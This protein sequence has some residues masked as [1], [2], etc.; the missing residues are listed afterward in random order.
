LPPRNATANE[1]IAAAMKQIAQRDPELNGLRLFAFILVFGHH[2]G[3]TDAVPLTRFLEA[4]GWVG[5][6]LFFALSAFLLFKTLERDQVQNGGAISLWDYMV[7]R[8]ARIY[9]LMLGYALI[10]IA[11]GAIMDRT[12]PGSN[13][14]AS[15]FSLSLALNN[16]VPLFGLPLSLPHAGHLWT[17]SFE[18]QVYAAVPALF[19]LY[20][21]TGRRKFI[22]ILG[23]V[24]LYA[25]LA[26]AALFALGAQHPT[27]YFLPFARPESYLIGM[28][29]WAAQPKWHWGYSGA[30]AC[31]AIILVAILPNP[32][33]DPVSNVVFYPA[34][35]LAAGALI[36]AVR[37]GPSL[38][39]VFGSA[40]PAYLG[41]RGYGLYVYHVL[42]LALAPHL[43]KAFGVKLE[44]QPFTFLILSATGLVLTVV[45]SIPSFR[46]EVFL[47]GWLRSRF[48]SKPR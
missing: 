30:A 8:A 32:W 14:W 15:F 4:K 48:Q 21:R 31:V 36:D 19:L 20:R 9:P 13:V 45:V 24:A 41:E 25:A 1:I 16:L 3:S 5:V 44:A 18:L 11:T 38:R 34:L 17:L 12:L 39:K 10:A 2:I 47:Q 33:A 28:A 23:C 37:R 40:I 7:R 27:I 6:D 22:V 43:L 46:L 26:R 29:L 35:A 42:A